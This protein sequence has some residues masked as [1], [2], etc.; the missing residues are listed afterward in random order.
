MQRP[1][2]AIDPNRARWVVNLRPRFCH[3]LSALRI[4]DP[5]CEHCCPREACGYEMRQRLQE[6]NGATRTLP[7]Y[8]GGQEKVAR[9]FDSKPGEVEASPP[10]S[11]RAEQK[12]AG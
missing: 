8:D 2:E 5:D 3:L 10:V 11:V 6:L 12:K 1:L 4:H 9:V 7:L